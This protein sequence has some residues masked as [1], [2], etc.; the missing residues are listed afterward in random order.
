M[1]TRTADSNEMC[2]VIRRGLNDAGSAQ[3]HPASERAWAALMDDFDR[4]RPTWV[5]DTAAGGLKGYG[6]YPLARYRALA[7]L[8]ARDYRQAGS[9][10]GSLLFRRCRN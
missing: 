8:L 1:R 2:S 4:R 5:L 6:K 9:V 7:A 3:A 10:Q